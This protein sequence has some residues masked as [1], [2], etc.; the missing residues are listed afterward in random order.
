[1]FESDVY[2][3]KNAVTCGLNVLGFMVFY[4]L[5]YGIE[6]FKF[7]QKDF[8]ELLEQAR[9]RNGKLN[10][11][12]KLI[13]CEGTFIQILEGKE[14]DVKNVYA[15]ILR[16]PRMVATKLVTEGNVKARHFEG[17]NMDFKE[18]SLSTINDFENCTHPDVADYI[19]S[20]PAIKLLKLLTK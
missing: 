17:W 18:I 13:Y 10:I 9:S 12:G 5:Y 19:N 8:E 11:T 4:L 14:Q 15:S 7:K 2:L 6:S 1:M 16:D 20:A 3:Q